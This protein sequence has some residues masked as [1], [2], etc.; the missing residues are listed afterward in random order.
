[1]NNFITKNGKLSKKGERF[2]ENITLKPE[3]RKQN[4]KKNETLR[5]SKIDECIKLFTG[6]HE[7]SNTRPHIEDNPTFRDSDVSNSNQTMPLCIVRP[8][9]DLANEYLISP[10][11]FGKAKRKCS[12]ESSNL[13]SLPEVETS[14]L[15]YSP[16]PEAIV[17]TE[18]FLRKQIDGNYDYKGDWKEWT[19]SYYCVLIDE[20]DKKFKVL[21]YVIL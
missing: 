3:S 2:R 10:K 9:S 7:T 16:K 6:M 8:L 17:E 21:P 1:M 11:R 15:N 5:S 20:N 18:L 19:E 14:K 12:E 4:S 13:I